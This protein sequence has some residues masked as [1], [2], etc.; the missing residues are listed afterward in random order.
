MKTTTLI[1]ALLVPYFTLADIGCIGSDSDRCRW[2][3]PDYVLQATFLGLTTI[4]W[5]QTRYMRVHFKNSQEDINPLLKN[6]PNVSDVAI[7]FVGGMILHT[8]ISALLPKPYR[9]IWQGAWI[10]TEG[11]FVGHNIRLRAGIKLS[12]PW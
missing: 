2:E 1:L 5:M 8:T 9:S 4:D 11:A 6:H 10:S 7:H 12:L 3:T